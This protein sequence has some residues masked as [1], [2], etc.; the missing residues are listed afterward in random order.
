MFDDCKIP[1]S[2]AF[3]Y[4]SFIQPYRCNPVPQ[5]QKPVT[6]RYFPA[7]ALR[8]AS[9]KATANADIQ[10]FIFDPPR[11]VIRA[12]ASSSLGSYH[13][14]YHA[15]ATHSPIG[16]FV[17]CVQSVAQKGARGPLRLK[18][19]RA[20]PAGA[21]FSAHSELTERQA[22][23]TSTTYA[24]GALVYVRHVHRLSGP[25]YGSTCTCTP[26]TIVGAGGNHLENGRRSARVVYHDL[27][28]ASHRAPAA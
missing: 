16:A 14:S 17:K 23:A 1:V 7:N 9:C 19:N 24:G 26:S 27:L 10:T 8:R 15:R 28:R 11:P 5:G 13:G 20:V 22:A 2:G 12:S 4:S 18:S 6:E 3:G 25:T 21:A